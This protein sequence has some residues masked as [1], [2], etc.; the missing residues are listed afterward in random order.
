M[1]QFHPLRTASAAVLLATLSACGSVPVQSGRQHAE[2]LL[3]PATGRLTEQAA[4]PAAAEQELKALLAA[5]LDA[6]GAVRIA[7]LRGPQVQ[8]AYVQLGVTAA[9]VFEAS[10]PANPRLGLEALW[11]EGAG[12][13]RKLA[14]SLEFNVQ[15]LLALHARRQYSA[16]EM[17]AA[18]QQL[19]AT[20]H[21]LALD[22]QEAWV[23]AVAADQRVA[24]REAID[25]S[26]QLGA[27]LMG[28]YRQ[29]GN[30]SQIELA[31]QGA[32]ASEARISLLAAR[33]EA[34]HARAQL[35]TLLGLRI[36]DAAITLPAELPPTT[37]ATGELAQ[38]RVQALGARLDLAAARNETEALRQRLAVA[39]RYRLLGDA[40]VGPAGERDGGGPARYGLG[41]GLELPL[42]SQGQG[43]ITRAESALQAGVARLRQAE[44]TLDAG[45]AEQL[46]ALTIA[47]Q[48]YS[49]YRG[50]LIPQVE[51]I[52]SQ[53]SLQ[54][55][56]ML[57]G[58]FELLE[59]RQR[60]YAA[61]E[62]AGDALRDYW[63][64]RIALSRT[65]GAPL[66][67]P[68]KEGPP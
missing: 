31:H 14:A 19:A 33:R 12:P 37:P 57:S 52:V 55:N 34:G 48:Q 49:L 46:E 59:A 30:V 21:G 7:W 22:V 38:L 51:S 20:L 26:A 67:M 5:P 27:D 60:A 41:L 4:S 3:Q 2:S 15:G 61:W 16:V 56:A 25:E 47:E 62:G 63:Q 6:A 28:Q 68:A 40:S 36:D 58:P 13:G 11:P 29:A 8:L 54:G 32:T 66:P 44:A 64:A 1:M 65:L 9:E 23:Q 10:R 18:E 35:R 53:L 50:Q 43:A 39:R 24:V 45:L 42:F 17:Q